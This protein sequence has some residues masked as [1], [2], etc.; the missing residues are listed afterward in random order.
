MG[1]AIDL[2]D[3]KNIQPWGEGIHTDILEEDYHKIKALSKSGMPY[4]MKSMLQ[5]KAFL[6]TEF[7]M[8]PDKE[9]GQLLHKAL[10][11]PKWCEE[12]MIFTTLKQRRGKTYDTLVEDNPGKVILNAS[13]SEMVQGAMEALAEIPVRDGEIDLTKLMADVRTEVSMLAKDPETGIIL[14]GRTDAIT[15]DEQYIIDYKTTADCRTFIEHPLDAEVPSYL[16]ESSFQKVAGQFKYHVQAAFYLWLAELLGE[17]KKHY[18]FVVQEKEP[19]YDYSI[20][21]LNEDWL[22]RGRELFQ[23]AIKTIAEKAKEP[24][25]YGY[26][27][28]IRTIMLPEKH[29]DLE[30]V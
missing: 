11:E 5:L 16:L 17:P 13:Q 30:W 25:W 4:G 27:K 10:L 26:D 15:N 18:I 3:E 2:F 14:K 1:N 23:K 28:R 8:T 21:V 12:N 24:V 20:S 29:M 19:P 7:K 6:T 9:K 22:E